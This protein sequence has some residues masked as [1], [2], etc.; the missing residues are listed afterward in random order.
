MEHRT[1]GRA[2]GAIV[3]TA[4]VCC[5]VMAA[6]DGVIQPGYAGKSAVK[7]GMFLLLPLLLSRW[8]REIQLKSLF[9]VQ[10]GRF[11]TALLLGLGIYGLIV[12]GYVL[13][14][15]VIDFSAIVGALSEDVGV[16]RDNF[17]FVAL[18]ISLINSLL[19]EFFFRGFVFLNLRRLGSRGFAHGFSALLFAV[20]HVAMMLGWFEL[21]VFLLALLGLALGGVLFN[22]LD[23]KQGTLYNSWLTHMFANFAINTVGFLL[24]K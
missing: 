17:L 20:Y 4:A 9:R 13:L 7:L 18:Y 21:W 5:A 12:G 2:A 8:N 16:R 19:E 15:Q 6:V 3:G 22:L 24:M 23:E 10:K 14:A 11:R 1:R